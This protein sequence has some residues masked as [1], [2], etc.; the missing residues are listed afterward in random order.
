MVGVLVLVWLWFDPKLRSWLASRYRKAPPCVTSHLPFLGCAIEF[1]KGPPVQFI[2]RCFQD[3]GSIFTLHLAG[4]QMTFIFE[5][6]LFP[7]FF[8]ATGGDE[9]LAQLTRAVDFQ[10]AT[11]PFLCRCF[12]MSEASYV[13]YHTRALDLMRG[14]LL[15]LALESSRGTGNV[16]ELRR[17]LLE[18]FD[19]FWGDYGV[20]KPLF[21]LT[22]DAAFAASVDTLFGRR[23]RRQ[24]PD[25][26]KLFHQFDE[27]FELASSD[28]P[29]LLLPKFRHAQRSLLAKLDGYARSLERERKE[30]E[31]KG[32]DITESGLRAEGLVPSLIELVEGKELGSWLLAIL[33]AAESNTIPAIFWIL[34]FLHSP[35]NSDLLRAVVQQI[36][37][38]FDASNDD[39]SYADISNRLPLLRAVVHE[40]FRLRSA[41]VIVRKT[42][43][44]LPLGGYVIP[45]GHFLCLSPLWSHRLQNIY[46]DDSDEWN[47]S[48][49][50]LSASSSASSTA[51]ASPFLS[52]VSKPSESS[53]TSTSKTLEARSAFIA[54]GSGKYRCPG[55]FF[56]YLE[57]TLLVALVLRRYQIELK[58]PVPLP[59]QMNLVG[60]QKPI[61]DCRIDY[62][63]RATRM[64]AK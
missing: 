4:R 39:P 7:V 61:G 25:L 45:E 6:R 37:E 5:P 52:L 22:Q 16:Q 12:G 44:P 1:G 42:I 35:N 49:W 30:K 62:K 58:D 56:A 34:C 18:Q 38:V 47:P 20:S 8:G 28:I 13:A 24:E 3:L 63:L 31:K 51:G 53:A 57:A 59:D 50:D 9:T 26:A 60:L 48:R 40:T 19:A 46:G 43:A 11:M 21:R 32:E 55:Q 41:A 36:D 29:H 33:W 23:L 64:N 10:Q 14:K 17:S 15:P 2:R 54:F 27:W